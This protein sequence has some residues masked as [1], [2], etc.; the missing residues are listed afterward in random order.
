[1]ACV[2]MGK[3]CG[4]GS[5]PLGLEE[6]V[7]LTYGK[8]PVISVKTTA[9][10]GGDVERRWGK[11]SLTRNNLQPFKLGWWIWGYT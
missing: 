4:T 6:G 10:Q 3:D 11:Y 9:S 2:N 1:M 7:A 8:S 5:G